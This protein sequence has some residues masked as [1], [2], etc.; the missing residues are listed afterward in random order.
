M[1]RLF[2]TPREIDFIS[3]INKEL[4]KDVIGQKIYYYT[5]R[6]DLSEIHHVYEEAPEKVFDPP[7]EIDAL[8]SWEPGSYETGQFGIDEKY[9]QEV[10][11]QWRDLIDKGL[12]ETVGVGDYYSYGTNFFEITSLVYDSN[13]FGQIEHYTGITLSGV[14]ARKGQIR[15]DPIGPTDE[16]YSDPGA[17]Q[18]IFAQQRGFAENQLGKTNDER[19]LIEKGI[20]EKPIT[21][22]AEV[23][24]EGSS[25]D[26][27]SA[28]Y[29]ES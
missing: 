11:I 3:D 16:A 18:E 14:Q 12:A 21:G 7:I 19:A 5:V 24:P 26:V 23:S 10:Y 25:G 28:F 15:F 17:V 13:I 29:D 8:I 6:D 2:V 22:P 27:G 9:K 20:I 1:A 4:I